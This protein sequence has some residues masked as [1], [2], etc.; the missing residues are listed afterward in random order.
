MTTLAFQGSVIEIPTGTIYRTFDLRVPC[1]PDPSERVIPLTSDAAFIVAM[2]GLTEI[3]AIDIESDQPVTVV[4][5]SAAGTAQ[6]VPVESIRIVSR[7]VPFTAISLVR[8]AGQA[9]TV[10][11]I[12]GQ[13]S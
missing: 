8:V 13:S 4:L 10:R 6:S 12:L 7:A 9:T 2:D 3:N 5:T 1:S 11:L